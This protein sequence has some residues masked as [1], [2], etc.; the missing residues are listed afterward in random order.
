VARP[1]AARCRWGA[2]RT[3]VLCSRQERSLLTAARTVPEPRAAKLLLADLL[4]AK[5]GSIFFEKKKQK[6]FDY[7]EPSG[8]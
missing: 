5:Q 7:V 8:A 6:T 3:A 4:L 2:R 1:A